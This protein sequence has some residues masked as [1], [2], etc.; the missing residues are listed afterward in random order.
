MNNLNITLMHI[1]MLPAI[2]MSTTTHPIHASEPQITSMRLGFTSGTLY[3]V[4]INDARAAQETWLHTI[5]Q[6]INQNQQDIYIKSKAYPTTSAAC[7]AILKNEID[8]IILLPL[9]FLALSTDIPITPILTSR[10]GQGGGEH[11]V[12]VTHKKNH[13]QNV[14]QLKSLNLVISIKGNNTTPQLWLDT[15]LLENALP[16]SEIFFGTIKN[17]RK[18]TQ[19]IFSVFFKTA[20]VCLIPQTDLEIA[21]KLNPQL[22]TDLHILKQSPGYNRVI[23]CVQNSFYQTYGDRISQ[24][25]DILNQ[26]QQGHQLFTLFKVRQMVKFEPAHLD[27]IKNLLKTYQQLTHTSA[28]P[29]NEHLSK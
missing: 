10:S 17:V 2:L 21:M 4:D 13:I 28:G 27:N 15:M 3:D 16:T 23:I 26:T 1:W 9:E 29:K 19:A 6:S 7:D 14:E 25:I 24:T 12:L 18:T 20:D 11:V 22:E 8:A 5:L